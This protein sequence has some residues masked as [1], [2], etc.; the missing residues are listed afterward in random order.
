MRTLLFLLL[1][2]VAGLF[3]YFFGVVFNN[4]T[5]SVATKLYHCGSANY[6]FLNNIPEAHLA[7]FNIFFAIL[8]AIFLTL[9][10]LRK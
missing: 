10:I 6:S 4:R 7:F 9:C 5:F 2:F 1:S 8:F 3:S